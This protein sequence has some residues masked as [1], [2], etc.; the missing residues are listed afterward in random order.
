MNEGRVLG[1]FGCSN[2]LL[3]LTF[4]KVH[5]DHI[6]SKQHI[7][8][9]LV[10]SNERVSLSFCV[11]VMCIAKTAVSAALK[12]TVVTIAPKPSLTL[13]A[14]YVSMSSSYYKMLLYGQHSS[15]SHSPDEST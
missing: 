11:S 15:F 2:L 14:E 10:C 4:W 12:Y 7:F 9:A 6:R 3:P 13:F 8:Y 5:S 1:F